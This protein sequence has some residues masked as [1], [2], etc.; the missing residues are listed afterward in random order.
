MK[1][2][3][4]FVI[5]AYNALSKDKGVLNPPRGFKALFLLFWNTQTL[6]FS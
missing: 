1:T 6:L 5:E 4:N 2:L 3:D